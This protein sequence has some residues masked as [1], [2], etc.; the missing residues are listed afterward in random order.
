[1]AEHFCLPVEV[2]HLHHDDG[3]E[4]VDALLTELPLRAA[5]ALLGVHLHYVVEVVEGPYEEHQLPPLQ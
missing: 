1:M 2:A 4:G 3:L 5:E